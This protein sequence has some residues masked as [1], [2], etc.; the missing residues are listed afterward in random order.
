MYEYYNG[1]A[2]PRLWESE[3]TEEGNPYNAVECENGCGYW[4]GD[5]LNNGCPECGSDCHD[6]EG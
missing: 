5:I 6:V 3:A 1:D 4:S 2:D